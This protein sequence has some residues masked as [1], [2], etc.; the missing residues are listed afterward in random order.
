MKKSILM[1]LCF[2]FL[3]TYVKSQQD[4]QFTQYFDNTLFVNP[5]YAGSRGMLNITSMHREQWAGFEGRPRSTTFSI[6]SPLK[7]ESVGLGLTM[8]SDQSGPVKQNMFYVDFSYSIKFQNKSKLVFG[9]KG[10][11]NM[12]SIEKSSLS[13]TVDSDPK[14]LSNVRNS[15]NPNFG[16]G[17]FYHS[18]NFFLGISSPK[19]LEQSYDV[20]KTDLERR[21]YFL[22]TGGIVKLNSAWKLRPSIQAKYAVGAP[23][24]VD[25]SCAGI[26]DE[27]LWL[28]ATYRLSAACGVFVQYQISN[29]F[30]VGLATDFGTQKIRNYNS[31]TFEA[32]ISYDFKFNKAGIRSPRFF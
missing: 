8:V 25:M 19:I 17:I 24:S 6:H 30:K 28:G 13:T 12:I 10:G 2:V 9:I 7:Y 15:I 3:T 16:T 27:K 21:H 20:S 32:L 31:G 26:Y 5:A 18:E 29:Q 23:I 22:M 14:L 1:L 11:M 4:A